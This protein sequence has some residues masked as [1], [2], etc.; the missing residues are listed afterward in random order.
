MKTNITIVML[1][2]SGCTSNDWHCS[3]D[4]QHAEHIKQECEAKHGVG[5]K[6]CLA[7]YADLYNEACPQQK[8]IT[9]L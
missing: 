6:D 7:I 3:G 5:D 9:V 4:W 2:L 1:L 8:T